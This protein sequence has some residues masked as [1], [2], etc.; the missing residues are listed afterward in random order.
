MKLYNKQIGLVFTNIG[1][2]SFVVEKYLL[3]SQKFIQIENAI[4][5]SGT[6]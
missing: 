6:G 5:R 1:P 3:H 2:N 4:L